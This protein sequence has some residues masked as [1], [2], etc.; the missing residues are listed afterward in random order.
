MGWVGL[1]WVGSSWVRI[2]QFLMGWV[3]LGPAMKIGVFYSHGVFIIIINY[4]YLLKSQTNAKKARLRNSAN[5]STRAA[6]VDP[7]AELRDGTLTSGTENNTNLQFSG[8]SDLVGH[9]QGYESASCFWWAAELLKRTV[10]QLSSP[11]TSS[12]SCAGHFG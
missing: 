2:F 12:P 9:L 3:G 1:G 5:G 11:L 7:F 10:Q 4:T 8:R 6:L